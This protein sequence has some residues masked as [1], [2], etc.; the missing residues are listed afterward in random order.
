MQR[1]KR[2][3]RRRA[4]L[5]LHRGHGPLHWDLVVSAGANL[6]TLRLERNHGGWRVRWQPPHRRRYMTY[7]GPIPGGRGT[8]SQ[9]WAGLVQVAALSHARRLLIVR[10][11]NG[12]RIEFAADRVVLT[13]WLPRMGL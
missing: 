13:G 5:L 10:L 6:V 9:Q 3:M 4:R 11:S 1:Y 12:T 2:D 8:V 7:A